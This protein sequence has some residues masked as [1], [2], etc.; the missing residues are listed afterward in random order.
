MEKK[1]QDKLFMIV[2]LLLGIAGLT[3]ILISVFVEDAPRSV[4]TAGMIAV[5]F[6]TILNV[7]VRGRRK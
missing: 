4:M 2:T 1:T 5:A 7:V 6:G 3:L